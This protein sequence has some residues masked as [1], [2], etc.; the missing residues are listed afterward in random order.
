[1]HVNKSQS[2]TAAH[3]NSIPRNCVGGGGGGE[4]AYYYL[5]GG[6]VQPP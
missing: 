4:M 2:Q 1:M 5:G 6:G 3:L